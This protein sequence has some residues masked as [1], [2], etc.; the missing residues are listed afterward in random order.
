M[1]GCFVK[2]HSEGNAY[3]TSLSKEIAEEQGLDFAQKAGLQNATAEDLRSLTTEE[4]LKAQNVFPG[5]I[6]VDGEY[7]PEHIGDAIAKGR[8]HDVVFVN[9]TTRNEG[10]FFAGL[11][12]NSQGK[13]MDKETYQ[14]LLKI[15]GLG[16]YTAEDIQ[17]EYAAEKYDT[18]AEAYNRPYTFQDR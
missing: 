2:T 1:S 13:A 12:E 17:R 11:M 3:S 8:V 9:G 6:Y 16:K 15:V 5:T 18:L 14:S 4:V 10:D 7:V